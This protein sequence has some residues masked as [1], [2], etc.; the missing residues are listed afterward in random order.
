MSPLKPPNDLANHTKNV[1]SD[2]PK[3]DLESISRLD[4][5]DNAPTKEIICPS[6]NIEDNIS[7]ESLLGF[8]FV[9]IFWLLDND[10]RKDET[11]KLLTEENQRLKDLVDKPTLDPS[12]SHLSNSKCLFK[13]QKRQLVEGEDPK[14]ID[15]DLNLNGDG[16]TEKKTPG[17]QPGHPLWQRNVLT[18]EEATKIFILGQELENSPCPHCGES[19][20]RAPERDEVKERLI[21]PDVIVEK[22]YSEVYAFYC[23]KCGKYHTAKVPDGFWD[24]DLLDESILSLF[25]LFKGKI[26]ISMRKIQTIISQVFGLELSTGKINNSLKDVSMVLRPIYLEILDNIKFRPVLH[27]DETSFRLNKKSIYTWI[28]LDDADDLAV[29]KNGTRSAYNLETVLGNDY[30]GLINSDCFSVYFSYLKNKDQIKHQLCHAHL[31]R[32]FTYCHDR[33]NKDVHIY[34]RNCLI[35]QK[36]LFALARVFLSVKDENS[37]EYK[38]LRDRLLKVKDEFMAVA[39]DAPTGDQRAEALGKRFQAHG[40]KYF[41]FIDNKNVSPTNNAAERGLRS[42]VVDR[43]ICYGVQSILGS[44]FCETLWTIFA[45]LELKNI[46]AYEFITNTLRDYT[47]G[48]PLPSL[49]NIGQ[50]VDPIYM[51]RAQKELEELEETH[52]VKLVKKKKKNA[53]AKAFRSSSKYNPKKGSRPKESS[54]SSPPT[55]PDDPLKSK[56]E[57]PPEKTTPEERPSPAAPSAEEK[58][59]EAK[60]EPPPTEDMEL[61]ERASPSPENKP[62]SARP[63]KRKDTKPVRGVKSAEKNPQPQPAEAKEN[64]RQSPETAATGKIRPKFTSSNFKSKTS[65]IDPTEALIKASMAATLPPVPLYRHRPLKA[66]GT[67]LKNLEPDLKGPYRFPEQP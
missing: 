51:E 58:P 67:V 15:F 46:N 33:L 36:K 26:S 20:V 39:L 44:L 63:K 45:N 27:I 7:S 53:K 66:P 6:S 1:T 13:R 32:D 42:I 17:G 21:L 61:E 37:Q 11:I 22:E 60:P 19:L 24:D 16:S 50:T 12:N 30:S 9:L 47:A 35:A 48:K 25:T 40:E 38:D 52:K 64:R 57:P 2:L 3:S 8:L 28:F 62:P 29:F 49:L 55:T 18:K 34:G 23:P 31:K 65:P 56:P 14:D 54:A 10:T 43:K 59:P 4:S 5:K 41:T